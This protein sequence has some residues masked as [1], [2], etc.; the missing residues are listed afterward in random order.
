[1]PAVSIILPTHN[2]ACSLRRSIESVLNQSFADF[3][4]IVVDDCSTDGTL[5]VVRGIDD[6]RIR[7]LHSEKQMGAGGARN[8]GIRAATADLLAFQ[9][10]DDEWY[11]NKLQLQMECLNHSSDIGVVYSD[12][13]RICLDGSEALLAAP[14]VVN[15]AIVDLTGDKYCVQQ[16]GIGSC[17]IRR[18]YVEQIG[19]F[20]QSMPSLE[21]LELFI[22]LSRICKFKRLETPLVRYYESA[23]LSSNLVVHAKARQML[24]RIYKD[25]IMAENENFLTLEGARI[26]H[27]LRLASLDSREANFSSR[28]VLVARRLAQAVVSRLK[29]LPT[30][31]RRG[32]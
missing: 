22:R 6:N 30:V 24:L 21:D 1:M 18:G 31:K 19:G 28:P 13:L 9:D 3:E 16:L 15:D 23:G 12:M 32:K 11:Q 4:L 14:D 17:L 26:E 27:F 10:S 2:R 7:Y 25:Q 29:G 20:N 5:D 8:C